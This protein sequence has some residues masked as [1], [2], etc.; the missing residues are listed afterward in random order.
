M[1]P[2][3]LVEPV[4]A[5]RGVIWKGKGIWGRFDQKAISAYLVGHLVHHVR[6]RWVAKK[7]RT[8]YI[9]D[10]AALLVVCEGLTVRMGRR[11]RVSETS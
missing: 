2:A 6:R 10:Q 7:G 8:A 11:V 3:E 4:T 1:T 9:V 5:K